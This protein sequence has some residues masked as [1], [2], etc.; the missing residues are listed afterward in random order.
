MCHLYHFIHINNINWKTAHFTSHCR[1]TILKEMFHK[2]LE[3]GGRKGEKNLGFSTV[4]EYLH[5][6]FAVLL[7]IFVLIIKLVEL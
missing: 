2:S 6:F 3:F 7:F 1:D 5:C 4:L